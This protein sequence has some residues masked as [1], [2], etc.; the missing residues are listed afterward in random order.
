M[1]HHKMV[2]DYSRLDKEQRS[3]N[4][5]DKFTG[6][7]YLF[8]ENDKFIEMSLF[9]NG[10]EKYRSVKEN[11]KARVTSYQIFECTDWYTQGCWSGGCGQWHYSHTHCEF[12][13]IPNSIGSGS[14]SLNTNITFVS[15][16]GSGT[17]S[18]LNMFSDIPWVCSMDF[19][20]NS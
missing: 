15:G 12:I 17:V 14:G 5:S 19:Y 1:Y 18:N 7:A 13:Y 8:D 16:G 20:V 2:Y 9:E 3:K 4:D 6:Y 10:E 11:D